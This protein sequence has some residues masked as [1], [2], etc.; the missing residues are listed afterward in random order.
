[1]FLLEELRADA[2]SE[3]VIG[4]RLWKVVLDN[5]WY[6]SR[7]FVLQMHDGHD[8]VPR[9]PAELLHVYNKLSSGERHAL[10][11]DFDTWLKCQ[12]DWTTRL[13]LGSEPKHCY[14][15]D[16]EVVVPGTRHA[17]APEKVLDASRSQA[18]RAGLIV[19]G[20][21]ACPVAE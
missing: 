4:V 19:A 2:E 20:L 11:D 17:L 10:I 13:L 6:A 14:I 9:T 12:P 3:A 15:G 5:C 7:S 16:E 1:M 18:L 8:G 21:A